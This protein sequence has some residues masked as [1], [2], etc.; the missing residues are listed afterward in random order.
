MAAHPADGSGVG[1]RLKMN[2]STFGA[3]LTTVRFLF[4]GGGPGDNGN[5]RL[6]PMSGL[7]SA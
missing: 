7:A 3:R 2:T 5:I 6:A 1:L 4:L